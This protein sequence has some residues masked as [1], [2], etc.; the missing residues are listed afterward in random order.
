MKD[1]LYIFL[2]LLVLLIIISTMGGSIRH[3]ERFY[4]VPQ[5]PTTQPQKDPELRMPTPPPEIAALLK[6]I[7]LEPSNMEIMLNSLA[8]DYR[9]VMPPVTTLAT[10]QS[11][12]PVLLEKFDDGNNNTIEAFDDAT[13]YAAY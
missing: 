5:V 11:A 1:V 4:Q 12:L 3:K 9:D 10:P 8:S 2:V 13:S 7:P 6:D